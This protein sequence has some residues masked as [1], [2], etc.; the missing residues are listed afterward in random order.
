M[1]RKTLF[2][3]AI[4]A[5]VAIAALQ[6][7]CRVSIQGFDSET[8]QALTQFF[9]RTKNHPGRKVAVF[10]GDGT[11]L[12][13][14]PH[15][16]ADECMYEFAKKHPDKHPAVITRIKPQSNVSLPY[17]R[18]RVEF[19][20]GETME[21]LRELGDDCFRR[22]YPG[23]IYAPM[24]QLIAELHKND[25]EVWI[26]TASPEALYQ[27]FL[28]RELGVP[29]W[30]ILG[31]KSV[32]RDGIVTDEMIEPVPQDEGKRHAI[33]TFVQTRPLFAAGNSRGD[34]E[35]INFSADFR[36]IVNPDSARP[37]DGGMSVEEMAKE[38]GWH[39][40]RIRDVEQ[41][42]FPGISS[43]EFGVRKNKAHEGR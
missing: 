22:T 9:E 25:F 30:R 35:M 28:S 41:P 20:A 19:F 10:D 32:V 1:R 4:L 17:V 36:M 26:I 16:L 29:V 23:K 18:G 40:V 14:V 6:I 5:L 34:R 12:G 27:K 15:Y 33:E 43:K 31:V 11:V 39:A 13:Q 37:A 21:G 7:S 24:K 3:G 8:N 38:G 2:P 42:G